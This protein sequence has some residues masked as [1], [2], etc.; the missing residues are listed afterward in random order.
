MRARGVQRGEKEALFFNAACGVCVL[1]P[2]YSACSVLVLLLLLCFLLIM[3]LVVTLDATYLPVTHYLLYVVALCRSQQEAPSLSIP[4]RV[5]SYPVLCQPILP[6]LRRWWPKSGQT[7]AIQAADHSP[8]PTSPPPSPSRASISSNQLQ[9]AP[10]SVRVTST[11][12]TAVAT[13][14]V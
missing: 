12:C 6:H 7:K 11:C 5:L 9:P 2:Y 3:Y 10:Y 14:T 4:P 13:A 8:A 1:E